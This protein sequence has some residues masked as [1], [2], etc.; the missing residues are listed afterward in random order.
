MIGSADELTARAIKVPPPS[1]TRARRP[2]LRRLLDAAR[3]VRDDVNPAFFPLLVV[4]LV[5][6]VGSTILLRF[7]YL[8]PPGMTWLDALY[9][10]AETITTVG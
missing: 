2:W 5:L 4:G 10:S 3:T 7:S 9:F 1:R 8:R 6:L